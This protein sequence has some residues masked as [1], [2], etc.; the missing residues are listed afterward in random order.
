MNLRQAI[1]TQPMRPFQIRV[2]VICIF[3][4]FV[5]G[6]EILIAG[7]VAPFLAKPEVWGLSNVETGW[8]LSAGTI[9]LAAG[10]IFIAPFADRIGRRNH[11]L[12]CLVLIIIGMSLSAIW[13]GGP[14]ESHPR[15]PTDPYVTVSRYTALVVL[16]IW[17][18]VSPRPSVRSTAAGWRPL[19][20]WP[21][22]LSSRSAASGTCSCSTAS[23]RC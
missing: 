4:A 19:L 21:W 5:D 13:S 20:P 22:W 14:G 10:G 8:L 18:P 16:V 17:R 11:I 15:A 6:F 12:G 23:D 9:G 1:A 2:I 3:L 7:Y